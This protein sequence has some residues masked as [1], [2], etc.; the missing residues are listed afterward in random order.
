MKAN[1]N[2]G[3]DCFVPGKDAANWNLSGATHWGGHADTAPTIR[4][5]KKLTKIIRVAVAVAQWGL[6]RGLGIFP[7][8]RIA[9]R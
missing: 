1:H 4:M 6:F 2:Y 3:K 9:C 8:Y 5:Q 7:S